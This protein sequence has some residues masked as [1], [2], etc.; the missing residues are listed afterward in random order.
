MKYDSLNEGLEIY[1]WGETSTSLSQS[2]YFDSSGT[3]LARQ[4]GF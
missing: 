3:D 4:N 2:W 1:T